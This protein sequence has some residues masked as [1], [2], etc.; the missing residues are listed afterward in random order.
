MKSWRGGIN[1]AGILWS[2]SF[3]EEKSLEGDDKRLVF[4]YSGGGH[5]DKVGSSDS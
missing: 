4:L 2:F 5:H 3:S 1:S